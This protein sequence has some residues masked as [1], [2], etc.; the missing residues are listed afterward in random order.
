MRPGPPRG[1]ACDRPGRTPCRITGSGRSPPRRDSRGTPARSFHGR[2]KTALAL[3]V[4]RLGEDETLIALRRDL[5]AAL[6]I[7]ADALGTEIGQKRARFAWDVGAHPPGV[8]E[9]Q[10]RPIDDLVDMRGASG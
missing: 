6:A 8:C 7:A 10:Q 3:V 1:I 2:H 5:R 9:R 4:K